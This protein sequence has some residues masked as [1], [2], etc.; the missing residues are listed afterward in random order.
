M[1]VESTI[2]SLNAY[3]S[4]LSLP[5][6]KADKS[7]GHNDDK[8]KYEDPISK[9]LKSEESHPL[10]DGS[11]VALFVAQKNDLP[12]SDNDA[13]AKKAISAYATTEK[14]NNGENTSP[15]VDDVPPYAKAARQIL[16]AQQER[17][18][19]AQEEREEKESRV[20]QIIKDRMR[21]GDL[22]KE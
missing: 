8:P 16:E 7:A 9:K 22:P 3:Q 10:T 14:H 15:K 5:A 1:A 17:A 18:E 19:K 21:N 2:N 4:G 20:L 11:E 13:L 6:Q 12:Q